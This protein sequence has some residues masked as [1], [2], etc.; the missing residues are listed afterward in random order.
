[1]KLRA[2]VVGAL[3]LSMGLAACG[4]G[5]APSS[6]KGATLSYG[7]ISIWYSNNAQE[8]TWGEQEVCLLYTSRCV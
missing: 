5:A 1:M 2:I 3:T 6:T 7:P 4:S 8:I